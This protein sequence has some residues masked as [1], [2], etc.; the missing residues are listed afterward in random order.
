MKHCFTR[1]LWYHTHCWSCFPSQPLSFFLPPPPLSVVQPTTVG[2]LGFLWPTHLMLCYCIIHIIFPKV[3]LALHERKQTESKSPL[4]VWPSL[5]P[6]TTKIALNHPDLN[7]R[8][9]SV[10]TPQ[11]DSKLQSHM[12][13]LS[14]NAFE[15]SATSAKADITLPLWSTEEKKN[16]LYFHKPQ[17]VKHKP[18][19]KSC[20]TTVSTSKKYK[21]SS[22]AAVPPP[23]F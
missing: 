2:L 20:L 8:L 1:W 11:P 14:P 17:F 18:S 13:R 23:N 5:I 9:T 6:E 7:P 12:F 22:F 16:L 19:L 3:Q 4:H 15:F 10:L 21:P